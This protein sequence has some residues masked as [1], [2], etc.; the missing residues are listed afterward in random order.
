MDN[1]LLVR[2]KYYTKQVKNNEVVSMIIKKYAIWL[3]RFRFGDILIMGTLSI[4]TYG[5]VSLVTNFSIDL[6]RIIN[7]YKFPYLV[8]NVP[9]D[10]KRLSHLPF[11]IEP[12]PSQVRDLYLFRHYKENL[13][14]ICY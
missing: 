2:L 7:P 4:A 12:K 1:K 5:L 9:L 13:E 6:R 10:Y 8:G 11:F 14:N 3:K